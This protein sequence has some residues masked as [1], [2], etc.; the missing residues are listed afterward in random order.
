MGAA[1]IGPSFVMV[2]ALAQL[3]L[4]FGGLHWI[5]GAFYGIGAAVISIIARSSVKLSRMA[6]GRD[7][8]LWALFAVAAAVTAVTESEIV[9]LFLG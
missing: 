9:W 3:Y 7:P 8:L 5:Q 1:F 6:L 2:L 4:R